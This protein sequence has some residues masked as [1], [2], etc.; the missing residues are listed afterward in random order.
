MRN[1]VRHS[2]PIHFYYALS[3]VKTNCSFTGNLSKGVMAN[4]IKEFAILNHF[5]IDIHRRKVINITSINWM[6]GYD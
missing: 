4:D 1:N 2:D 5:N 3:I 6:H